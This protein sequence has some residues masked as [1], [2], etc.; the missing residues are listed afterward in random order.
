MRP[1]TLSLLMLAACAGSEDEPSVW[2]ID[3]E[4]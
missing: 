3:K 2:A 4:G 1:V